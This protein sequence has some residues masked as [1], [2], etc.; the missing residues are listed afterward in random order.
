MEEQTKPARPINIAELLKDGSSPQVIVAIVLAA[1]FVVI[2][3]S[4]AYQSM[5]P[6]PTSTQEIV[7][8]VITWLLLLA[9]SYGAI[10]QIKEILGSGSENKLKRRACQIA[11]MVGLV[12]IVVL[13]KQPY[14]H[15]LFSDEKSDVVL[16]ILLFS[17]SAVAGWTIW[18][19]RNIRKYGE[20][21]HVLLLTLV[22]GMSW[23]AR[24]I[25][26]S[27]IQIATAALVTSCFL[28]LAK[29]YLDAAAEGKHS[30]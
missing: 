28:R 18:S 17:S 6:K 29:D 20:F 21:F 25:A 10:I 9:I 4:S 15:F 8:Y 22:A 2:L 7:V 14:L 11:I 30:L 5:D 3:F 27:D 12:L 24:L 26:P 19:L 16:R 13:F 23:Y 1:V